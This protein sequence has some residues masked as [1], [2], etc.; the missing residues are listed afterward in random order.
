MFRWQYGSITLTA[1][2]GRSPFLYAIG[3]GSYSSTNTFTGLA[4]GSY[5]L[6]IKDAND[7]IKDTTVLLSQPPDMALNIVFTKPPCNFFNSGSLTVTASN[8][9]APYDYALGAGTFSATNS[10]TS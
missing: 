8:G 1:S 9:I 6:H 3:S 5:A 7:C 2:G 10:F 4:A